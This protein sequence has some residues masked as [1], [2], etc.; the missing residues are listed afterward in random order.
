MKKMEGEPSFSQEGLVA[1]DNG[2]V[3]GSC[4]PLSRLHPTEGNRILETTIRGGRS[5]TNMF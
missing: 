1:G 2:P 3:P 4:H 5:L